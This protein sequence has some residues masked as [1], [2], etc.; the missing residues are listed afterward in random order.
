[1]TLTV[2]HSF[3]SAVPDGPSISRVKP[4]NWNALHSLSGAAD[5]SQGGTNNTVYTSNAPLY[6]DGTKL[7]SISGITWSSATGSF[8]INTGLAI[9]ANGPVLDV[10]QSW[11]NAAIPFTGVQF[12]FTGPSDITSRTFTIKFAGN[13]IFSVN[14]DGRVYFEF[15]GAVVNPAGNRI[16]ITNTAVSNF[17]PLDASQHTAQNLVALSTNTPAFSGSQTWN[18]SSVVFK[19]MTLNITD[20]LSSTDA[21][22][23][24]WQVGSSTKFAVDKSGN[25]QARKTIRADAG[26]FA[27]LPVTPVVGMLA[28]IT[29]SSVATWGSIIGGTGATTVLGFYNGTNWTVAGA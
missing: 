6:Y 4:S 21:L 27:S 10:T 28:T 1:M 25:L 19:A 22:L 15:A 11:N 29:D 12:D 17:A 14:K 13:N 24:D 5:L 3:V 7:G 20:T 16:Q 26:P 8:I 9:T 2:S 18:G 23:A